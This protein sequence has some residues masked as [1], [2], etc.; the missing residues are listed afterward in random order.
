MKGSK[1][2][3]DEI[4]TSMLEEII[5]EKTL[6]GYLNRQD[7]DKDNVH[8]FLCFLKRRQTMQV[9]EIKEVSYRFREIVKQSKRRSMLST[10]SKSDYFTCEFAINC[11]RM[12]KVLVR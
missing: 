8:K 5:R 3:K 4:H 10:F 9:D 11:E 2:Y 6:G 1:A 7:F 12:I